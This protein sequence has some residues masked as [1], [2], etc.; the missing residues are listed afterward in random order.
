MQPDGT[1]LPS[2]LAHL[3]SADPHVFDGILEALCEIVPG[4]R[5]LRF[6]RAPVKR[7]EREV[8][9]IDG[10][11]FTHQAEREYWGNSIEFD[12]ENAPRIPASM[13][14]EG[15]LLVLGLLTVILGPSRPRLL[16]LDDID[17]ALH[18]KAQGDLVALLRRLLDKFPEM[19]IVATSHSPYLLDH[20]QPEEVRLTTLK[21]DGTVAAGRLDEHPEFEKWRETMTP[22]EFWS[23]VGES[24]LVDVRAG[25]IPAGE[26]D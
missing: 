2:V 8:I 19:Q 6:P 3:A 20:L 24:W 10:K 26:K 14:S 4:V 25:D 21:D 12:M 17:R 9:T 1:G 5:G 16:L 18:P 23:M 22:G 11:Q 15:T 7:T 13:V